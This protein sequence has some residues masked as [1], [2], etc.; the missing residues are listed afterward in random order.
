VTQYLQ[1]VPGVIFTGDQ[2]GQLFIR[3]GSPTQTGIMLD[4]VTIYNPFHSIGLYSVF[5]TEAIRSV[6]VQSAGF[7]AEH[8]NRTSAILD[9]HT[10]DGN[11][12]TTAGVLSV[13]PIMTRVLLEGPLLKP[14][15]D[16][17]TAIT[18]VL[19]YKNSY[20]DQTSKSLYSSFGDA[21]KYGLPY[22][23]SDFFGK[24]SLRAENGSKV[25]AF[26]FNFTDNASLLDPTNHEQSASYK[27]KAS[28]AGASF[29]VSPAGSSTLID[30]KFAYSNYTIDANESAYRPRS[31]GISGFETGINFTNFLPGYSEVKYGIEI[32]G[33]NTNLTYYYGAAQANQAILD[34]QNTLAGLFVDWR[35]DFSD[36]F[37]FEPSI[38]FQ[39]Y[40][41]LSK[42]SPEPRVAM[43]YN[44]TPDVR[45][46]FAAGYYTQDIISTKSDRDIVDLFTGFMLSPDQD[47]KN[48][49]GQTLTTNLQT[50]YHVLGGVEVD[51]GDVE[52][53]VEPWMKKFTQNIIL[54][55]D[56]KYPTDADFTS[57]TSTAYGLDFTIK[58]NI[59]KL[60][61]W[62][63]LSFQKVD[64]TDMVNGQLQTYPAPFDRRF[65]GNFVGSY[66]MGKKEEWD[67]SVRFN[68]GSPFPFTQTQGY[69]ENLNML[70]NGIA[71]NY[72]QQN[73]PLSVLYAQ[74][75]NGGRLSWF[76]RLDI[77]IKRNFTI[78]KKMHMDATFGVTN[79][80]NR[81]NIFYVNRITNT[82][83]YQLPLFP[84]LNL[85]WHF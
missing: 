40:S 1:V 81:D 82:R 36:K 80:Y 32:S 57:G 34:R 68:I 61:L 85:T 4:G 27:W 3:G 74:D 59:K 35:K 64:F 44:I 21:F 20:L 2:G 37:V 41:E 17:G 15:T 56:K 7:N 73:G 71:T 23:F 11:K 38:R 50:A 79:V 43:K 54:N 14:R 22:S 76:H 28:G 70:Q 30:G 26:G 12:N 58:Y 46:K 53:N 75:V 13:S 51:M 33:Y 52:F 48:N 77:S 63:V 16:N 25:N 42:L 49:S 6:D 66:K 5:E 31:S 19:S 72:L 18:Y 55:Q 9:I 39:Y 60:Y 62:T 84:S 69:Y 67:F 29:V 83:V 24:V 78:N 65:N 45:L 47:V 10:I 8:G